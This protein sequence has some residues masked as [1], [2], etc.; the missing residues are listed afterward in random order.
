MENK[1]TI[2]KAV[3]QCAV[4]IKSAKS[5]NDR[6]AS[7]FLVTKLIKGEDCNEPS[8]KLLFDAIGFEFLDRLLKAREVPEDCPPY[9]YKSVALSIVSAFCQ[10]P[11]IS[12]SPS[13]RTIIPVLLDVISMVGDDD[14][15]MGDSLM[16]V[17]DC[18]ETLRSIAGTQGGRDS[19]LAKGAAKNLSEI[20]VEE[21]FRH[22]EALKL[23]HYLVSTEGSRVWAGNEELFVQLAARLSNEF[24]AETTEKKFELCKLL[25]IFLSHSP[26]QQVMS[27]AME[28][29]SWPKELL[30]T[31]EG[32]LCS[33]V[34]TSQRDVALQLIA[35]LLE[36]LGID[37]GLRSGPNAHQFLL[38]LVNL[39]CVEVRMKLEDKSLAE[40]L[41]SGDI[42]VACYSI[43]ELFVNFMTSQSFLDFDQK[44]RDQAYCALKGAV[45][46]ILGLLQDVM[47]DASTHFESSPKAS[48]DLICASIRVLG[49]WLAEEASSMRKEVCAVLPH[50][51]AVCKTMNDRRNNGDL[52]SVDAFR[53]ML[54]AFC[55]LAA[56]DASRQ[57]MLQQDLHQQLYDYLLKQWGV[58]AQ[59]LKL[60]PALAADWLHATVGE[61]QEQTDM[62]EKSRPDSEAAVILV[63]GIYMNLVV[64]EP[65]L[66]AQHVVFIQLLRFC[67]ANVPVLTKRQ[68]FLVLHGNM[69]VLGL[70]ILR[71]HSWKFPQGDSTIF[72]YIQGTVSFLWDAHNSEESCE[73]LSLRISLRY[74]KD[75]PDLAEMWFLGMQS[76]S[77]VL[78]A[79]EWIVDFV[80]DSGWPQ[81]MIKSLA[82]IRAGAIDAST[83][84]AYEDFLCCL[85]KAQPA[86]KNI[87]RDAGGRQTCRTHS[88]RQLLALIS[89]PEPRGPSKEANQRTA[90]QKKKY[91][92]ITIMIIIKEK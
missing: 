17:S 30:L 38:L 35:R 39:A 1:A 54:P 70:L 24:L 57:I 49:A 32:I 3:Q 26:P 11:D 43:M 78:P 52:E 45:S 82:S 69:A 90:R 22:D 13:V 80:V 46:A 75:W 18:Y 42:L 86:V 92:K 67:F 58:F 28:S 55:H 47:N 2:S 60:Q 73:E 44:Q 12:K 37:W 72:R 34:G 14:D 48:Q 51:I 20:Y 74:K 56:E 59:W 33:K 87:I 15:D 77:N 61:T 5:D 10:V 8:L 16:L 65:Q 41:S 91:K 40:V 62:S 68:D 88:M 36:L 89:N 66:C 76:L 63:C 31:L 85:V 27:V 23:L 84:T 7:L 83:R 25:A 4:T 79:M 21:N 53:F 50:I 6:F 9:I 29:Q 64:L 81:E 71:Q 19:L